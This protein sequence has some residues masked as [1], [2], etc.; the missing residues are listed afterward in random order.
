M[1][2]RRFS[3]IALLGCAAACITGAWAAGK[4]Y[5]TLV[6]Q[7]PDPRPQ[8]RP[9]IAVVVDGPEAEACAR[10]REQLVRDLGKLVH[11]RALSDTDVA[12][13][14]LTLRIETP[15]T[16]P[17]LK[18][19][20]FQASLSE[21]RGRRLWLVDGRTEWE[22]PSSAPEFAQGISRNVVAALMRDGW[23]Q[24]RYD[25]NDPPPAAPTIRNDAPS[26]R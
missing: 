7:A 23:L 2:A 24:Q 11:T 26:E 5:V 18:S 14:D 22:G 17:A 9:G 19:V 13:Y 20:A 21:P 25:A 1:M 10:V 6:E 3:R 4:T 12:D 15:R 16:D 8:G